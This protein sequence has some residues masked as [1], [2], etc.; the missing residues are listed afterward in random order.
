MKKIAP[1]LILLFTVFCCAQTTPPCGTDAYHEKLLKT[2]TDYAKRVNQFDQSAHDQ[3]RTIQDTTLCTIPVVVHVMHN[4]QAVGTGYNVSDQAIKDMI[5]RLNQAYRNLYNNGSSLDTRIQFALAVRD[6][7]EQCT[8]GINR[9]NM[10]AYNDYTSYGVASTVYSQGLPEYTL[11]AASFWDS[12]DYYNIWVVNKIDN[13]ALGGYATFPGAHGTAVDGAVIAANEVSAFSSIPT[14]ELG[15]ALFLYH[16]FEGDNNGNTC[17]PV[18]G[19]GFGSGDCCADTSAHKRDTNCILTGTDCYGTTDLSFKNNYMT[20]STGGCINRFTQNQV[21][22]MRDAL[23]GTRGSLLAQ[24]GNM[25]LIPP[26][27][28][29]MQ[30]HVSTTVPCLNAA[31]YLRLDG[32]CLAD[33]FINQDG[34]NMLA[35]HWTVTNGVE[36]SEYNTRLATFIPA[37]YGI[38]NVSLTITAPDNTVTLTAPVPLTVAQVPAM[39]CIPTPGP[40]STFYGS[41]VTN[42]SFNNIDNTTTNAQSGTYNN[43]TCSYGTYVYPGQ[44]YP[45]VVTVASGYITAENFSAYIDFNNDGFFAEDELALSGYTPAN[46]INTFT[47]SITI[48]ADAVQNTLLNMRIAAELGTLTSQKINCESPF[49]RGDIEDYTVYVTDA[50]GTETFTRNSLVVSPNPANDILNISSGTAIDVVTVYNMLGQLVA[51]QSINAPTGTVD[52][53]KLSNGTY[54]VSATSGGSIQQQKV[55]KK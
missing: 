40:L 55:I 6:P 46:T 10:G 25:S 35:Y 42:V 53:S 44:S 47:A 34:P 17:P 16:T 51:T 49:V 14:H 39:A 37:A 28:G 38:Y 36:T 48:P 27:L 30:P 33:T 45:L 19:C 20:Y 3:A 24:N 41:A 11:K 5:K 50:L 2:N 54:L 18:N 13:G 23:T 4:G 12:H 29:D 15:H 52:I 32:G 22:R 21:T 7:A 31:V 9:V 1:V 26:S 43:F 8:N